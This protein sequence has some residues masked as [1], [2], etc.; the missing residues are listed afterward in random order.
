LEFLQA[1]K[2]FLSR[3]NW[4][5]KWRGNSRSETAIMRMGGSPPV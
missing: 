3:G 2:I 5:E 1:C 4:Q